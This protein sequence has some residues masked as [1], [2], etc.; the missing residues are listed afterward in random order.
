MNVGE[1]DRLQKTTRSTRS[2]GRV[3]GKEGGVKTETHRKQTVERERSNQSVSVLLYVCSQQGDTRPT[4]T[5]TTQNTHIL[6][7]YTNLPTGL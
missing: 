4:T 6:V 1:D 3:S 5:N 2:T 7:S